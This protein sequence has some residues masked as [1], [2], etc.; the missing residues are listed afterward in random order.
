MAD[1]EKTKEI[2]N[3]SEYFANRGQDLTPEKKWDQVFVSWINTI[4]QKKLILNLFELKLWFESLEEFFSSHYLEKLIFKYETTGS[5]NYEYYV[6][7]FSQLI[8]RI[9][10]HLKELDF[11]K[12]K[13]LLNFEEFIVENILE[14][15]TTKSF[16]YIKDIYST[17]SWFY[18]L[19]IFLQNLR[20][21]CIELTRHNIVSHKTLS[22]IKKLYHKELM[23][24]SILI[25][26]LKKRFIP[27]M[28]K[29]YQQDISDII[30]S[31]KDKN[32]KRQIGIFFIFSFRIMKINN[33]IE[34]TLNKGRQIDIAIPLILS[35]KK[36]IEDLFSFYETVLKKGFE[37]TFEEKQE[38]QQMI[39]AFESFKLEYKKIFDGELPNYFA[40][41]DEKINKRKLLKNIVII[42]D[43][44]I[45]EFIESILK[46]FK[47]EISGSNIFE[48]YISRKEKSLEVKKKLTKLHQKIND[49]FSAK[50]NI[51]APDIF[52]DIN[53][54]IETDLNYLLY[55]DWN[56][57][58]N[59]YNNLIRTEFSSEF[60][61][62]LRSFHSF[63][64]RV[65]KELVTDNP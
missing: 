38:L 19:R 37:T 50:G 45:Q 11:K 16:P 31:I 1:K 18:T 57:F 49:F 22:S 59:Y 63:I 23:N 6:T 61:I 17:E 58:L 53:L 25:S 39:K 55:K 62:N 48:N 60:K 8:S 30:S 32:L 26:L 47:P 56:E 41:T 13:H 65:L 36:K 10:N 12:D 28:D 20:G 54:F 2:E 35:L 40:N 51:T 64:T 21:I 52:F 3:I 27:K 33:F 34:L 4:D 14:S 9:I 29:I 46:L 5:R 42:S 15:Y 7:I 43:F 44:A 24:N